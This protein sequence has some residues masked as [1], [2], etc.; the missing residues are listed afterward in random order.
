MNNNFFKGASAA[1]T[2]VGLLATVSPMLYAIDSNSRYFA[3][4]MGQRSCGDYVKLRERRLETLE[5]QYERYTKDE[6]YE[7]VDK[8][9]EH[10]IAGFLTAHNLYVSDTYDVAGKSNM[11]DLKARLE[12]SCRANDKQLFAEAM[13][14]LARE[15]HPQRVRADAGK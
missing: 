12:K 10:W 14:A 3:Y 4:G 13:I 11:N 6:L 15:L 2:V 9:V 7:I 8:I 5:Q 1:L